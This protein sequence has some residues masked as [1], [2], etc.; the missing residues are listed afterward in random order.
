[1]I[2]D[3]R[4]YFNRLCRKWRAFVTQPKILF[5]DEPICNLDASISAQVIAHV[6][7]QPRARYDHILVTRDEAL[8]S[9]EENS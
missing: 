4:S 7:T 1:M 2:V 6:G 5:A 9:I 3:C 8:T